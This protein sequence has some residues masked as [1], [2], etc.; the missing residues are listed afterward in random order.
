MP[1]IPGG[2]AIAAIVSGDGA[3][4]DMAYLCACGRSGFG[5]LAGPAS[6]RR[7][8]IHWLRNR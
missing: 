7:V 5:G 6:M 4:D 8:I 2:V 1:P 3:G